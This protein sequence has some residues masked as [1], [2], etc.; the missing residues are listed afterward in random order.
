M[1]AYQNSQGVWKR[2]ITVRG[3]WKQQEAARDAI[4]DKVNVTDPEDEDNE[5]EENEDDRREGSRWVPKRDQREHGGNWKNPNNFHA[6]S[7]ARKT[8]RG[9]D[10]GKRWR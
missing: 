8:R 6:D 3:N 4:A 9:G 5:E 10:S 7:G 2:G 1:P